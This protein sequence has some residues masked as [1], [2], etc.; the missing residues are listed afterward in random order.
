[1]LRATLSGG[2]LDYN[3]DVANAA[4]N[5]LTL[6]AVERL[7]KLFNLTANYTYSHTIDNGNFTTFINLP[8][9]QFDYASERGNSNQDVRH[10]F[11]ANFTADAPKA[12]F[13]YGTSNSAASSPCSPAG[14][15]RYSP[16]ANVL[17][18]VAGLST[19]RVGGGWAREFARTCRKLQHD[20]RPKHLHRRPAVFF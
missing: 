19:D 5:G 13:R 4:Y 11:V 3:N 20:D 2:L 17:G 18:D 16:G 7:G 10:H 1:M 14:P 12:E 9:N 15:L 6:T 8:P